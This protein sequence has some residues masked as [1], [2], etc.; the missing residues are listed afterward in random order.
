[1]SKRPIVKEVA[2]L[3]YRN[4]MTQYAIAAMSRLAELYPEPDSRVSAVQIATDRN[5]PRPVVAKV[6]SVLAQAG[7]VRG[8]PGPGGGYRLAR[9]PGEI[10]LHDVVVLFESDNDVDCPFGPGWCGNNTP[11]PL[12]DSLM[13]L[14]KMAIDHLQHTHF[15]VFTDERDP[16]VAG[17]LKGPAAA[18]SDR[19]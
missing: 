1:M 11:C 18:A 3:I 4:R 6:L 5:L 17:L 8:A 2:G 15:D 19:H 14:K 16:D 7:L 10:S 9:P 12:H 13:R